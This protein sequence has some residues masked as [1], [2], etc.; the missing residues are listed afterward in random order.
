MHC[1]QGPVL[2]FET[3]HS[4]EIA[5]IAVGQDQVVGPRDRGAPVVHRTD[6]DATGPEVIEQG[7]GGQ[8]KREN[9]RRRVLAREEIEH[10]IATHYFGGCLKLVYVA[11]IFD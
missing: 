3:G 5:E 7:R 4:P 6:P 9:G 11:I 2:D 1:L 10:A 8:V